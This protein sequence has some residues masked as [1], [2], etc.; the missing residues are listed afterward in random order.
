M[1]L[2]KYHEKTTAFAAEVISAEDR[3]L[4]FGISA[5]EARTLYDGP[6]WAMFSIWRL[7]R[8]VRRDPLALSDC[9]TFPR[10]DYVD[11]S[12]LFPTGVKRVEGEEECHREQVFMARGNAD[13]VLVIQLFDSEA[14]REGTEKEEA[15]ESVE[16]RCT[17]IW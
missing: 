4:S 17:V 2:R 1:H 6:R 10:D 16:V 3:Q 15:R 12:V 9:R 5:D 14:E 7:L 8:T 13:E 11:F